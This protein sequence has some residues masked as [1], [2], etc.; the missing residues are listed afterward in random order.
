M[1]LYSTN[2]YQFKDRIL[3]D[4]TGEIGPFRQIEFLDTYSLQ[5]SSW[6]SD[7]I[8]RWVIAGWWF[9]RGGA[10]YDGYGGGIFQNTS[11]NATAVWDCSFRLILT[12]S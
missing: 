4:A 12:P 6:Y 1:Y 5:I 2:R 7:S 8:F 9:Q 11:Y 10:Y 3:G